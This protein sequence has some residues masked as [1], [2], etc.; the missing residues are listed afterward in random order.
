MKGQSNTRCTD[1]FIYVKIPVAST[2]IFSRGGNQFSVAE[3]ENL[4]TNLMIKPLNT[5]I[6]DCLEVYRIEESF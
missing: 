6:T 5:V 1:I 2:K 4:H 3:P